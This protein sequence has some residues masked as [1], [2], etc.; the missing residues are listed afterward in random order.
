MDLPTRDSASFAHCQSL[1][2]GSLCK[3]LSLIHQRA[4]RRSKRNYNPMASRTENQ[5]HRKLL[6][7]K[8]QRIISQLKEQ[9]KTPGKQLNEV[10]I[11]NLPETE[12]RIMIGR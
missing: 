8:R 11:G 1:P 10:E 6:K 3:P 4:G 2:S 9:D 7:M 5:N 12:F